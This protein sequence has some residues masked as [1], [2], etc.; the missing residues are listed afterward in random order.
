[1]KN[2]ILSF[3]VCGMFGY[4][5]VI[6]SSTIEKDLSSATFELL[7][8]KAKIN[9]EDLPESVKE[10]IKD[11]Y[12]ESEIQEAHQKVENNET[13]YII[14]FDKDKEG[15]QEVTK[16]FDARG[17]E[18]DDEGQHHS[19]QS[20]E[21]PEPL[22]F[23][24]ETQQER[25]GEQT[26]PGQETPQQQEGP[27]RRGQEAGEEEGEGEH[28]TPGQQQTPQEREGGEERPGEQT[29]ETPGQPQPGQP[30]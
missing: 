14:K 21:A 4:S 1:M 17:D 20:P 29:P 6:A 22:A 10:S 11:K 19:P 2:L 7:Q 15:N 5:G 27:V 28:T 9:P 8:D 24:Q 30:Q 16:K 12:Q 23:F 18:V 25:E 3:A 13:Y 26:S